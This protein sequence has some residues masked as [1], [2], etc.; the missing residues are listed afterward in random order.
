MSASEVDEFAAIMTAGLPAEPVAHPVVHKGAHRD[1]SRVERCW[2]MRVH[3]MTQAAI[4]EKLGVSQ[5]AVSKM[6]AAVRESFP[7]RTREELVMMTEDRY[8][9]LIG[10]FLPKAASGD[11]EACKLVLQIE[12]DRRKLLGLDA[13]TATRVEHSG[14][15]AVV[16]AQGRTSADP[17]MGA[18]LAIDH[19]TNT[20]YYSELQ[21][22]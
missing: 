13:P 20:S 14:S 4:A 11:A 9:L 19:A 8:S 2:Q 7:L 6:L 5:P 21:R 16:G 10:A 15:V 22:E 1:P 12:R 17:P 18:A 3:G